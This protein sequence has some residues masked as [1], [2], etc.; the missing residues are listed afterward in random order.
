MNEKS[1]KPRSKS[2]V[3]R[4]AATSGS[5]VEEDLKKFEKEAEKEVDKFAKLLEGKSM[6]EL[7]D[8]HALAILEEDKAKRELHL[9]RL[10]AA[11]MASTVDAEVDKGITVAKEKV[12]ETIAW[13]H[14]IE[15]RLLGVP[16]DIWGEKYGRAEHYQEN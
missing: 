8:L 6:V 14:A 9:L 5:D 11:N 7:M 10:R 3:K 1:V 2:Q 16:R 12:A 15:K 4:F 13:L